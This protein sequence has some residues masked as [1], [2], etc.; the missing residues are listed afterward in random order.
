ME[1]R[2][3]MLPWLRGLATGLV[4]LLLAGCAQVGFNHGATRL[5]DAALVFGRLLLE[6]DGERTPVSTFSTP[7]FLR[8]LERPDA[9]LQVTDA[10]T[11]DGRFYWRLRPG[12]YQLGITL[13]SHGQEYVTYAFA[14]DAAAAYYF[15]DLVIAGTRRFDTLGGANIRNSQPRFEDDFD[16]ARHELLARNP[17]LAGIPVQRLTLY[18]MKDAQ[19]RERAYRAALARHRPCCGGDLAQLRYTPLLPGQTHTTHVGAD[20]PVFDFDSGRSRVLAYALPEGGA[21]RVL[22]IR[23]VVIPG[24]LM[25]L[26]RVHLFAPVVSLL[27]AHHQVIWR[28]E[29]GLFRPVPA[30]VFPPRA[31]AIEA[32]LPITGPLAQARYLVLHTSPA[33]L[34]SEWS[35]TRPGFIPIAGGAIPSGLPVSVS[36]EPAITGEVE[37]SLQPAPAR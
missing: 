6:R 30:S 29:S 36:L 16:H 35:S 20:T 14:V 18:D 10:L 26:Q 17:Q 23:S 11:P 21:P 8:D 9:P 34:A 37:V 3:P 2:C 4:L 32:Q 22:S 33:I 27:D 7:V 5:D 24:T 1:I 25:S 19:Q 28:Q 12:H 31:N 15:G 13:S